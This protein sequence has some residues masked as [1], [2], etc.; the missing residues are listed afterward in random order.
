MGCLI[1][2]A[3]VTFIADAGDDLRAAAKR[4]DLAA[5]TKLLANGADVNAKSGYG[6][7]ALLAAAGQGHTE[8]VKFLL[9]HKADPNVKDTFYG[10]SP[11][12][13][14]VSLRKTEMARALL[15]AGAREA[16]A[17]VPTAAATGE[18][19]LTRL[20]I[21]RGKPSEEILTRALARVPPAKNDVAELLTKAGA[22][23]TVKPEVKPGVKLDP[24]ALDALAGT[25]RDED[26]L[27]DLTL[28][29]QNGTLSA[30]FEFGP[31][32]RLVAVEDATFRREDGN[33]GTVSFRKDS[34]KIVGL[35][36]KGA[37]TEL[38]YKRLDGRESLSA[39]A[40][41]DEP[42]PRVQSPGNWPQFRGPGAAGVADGQHPPLRWDL[43]KGVNVLWKV[44]VAGLG[45]F[46]PVVWGNRVILTTAVSTGDTKGLKPGQ[47]GNVDSVEDT[48]EHSWRVLAF[49]T[50]TGAVVW[51]VEAAKGVPTVKRH[52]KGTHANPT[53]A[54][55]GRSVV[56]CF[57][58]EGLFCYSFDGKL[59]WKRSLG[60]LDSGWFFDA[61]Y[62]W[63]F[64]S[65]PILFGNA[66]I[67][68]CDVGVGSFIAAFDLAD[69]RELWRTP[70]DEIPSW[71]TPTV[72]VDKGRAELVT[73]ATRFARGYDPATGKELWRLGGHSEITVPTPFFG[74]GLIFI[75]SGYRPIKPIF[76]IRPGGSGDISLEKGQTSNGS[77]AWST[78]KGGP[79]MPTP[80]VY[81]DH[82]YVCG[83]DGV[84]TCFEARSGKPVYK[85]RLGGK[86]GYTASPVA[87]DGRLYF[88]SEEGGTNVVRAG[89]VFSLLATNPAGEVC[90][91]TPAISDGTL[92]IRTEK[93]LAAVG[94]RR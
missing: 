20:L 73:N 13:S 93:H 37:T 41:L 64:G 39:D 58:S 94:K 12:S 90:M 79:Y 18:L 82:L 26:S 78:S 83:N 51:D 87:A 67:V 56:A 11:L 86:G 31:T 15:D 14:A 92:F 43:E 80:I 61:D 60:K 21:E 2:A 69:G 33:P 28:S 22:K 66:V 62:Q 49:D 19:E 71:G 91:A 57:G 74:A 46:C 72:V 32:V 52:L 25:Y 76:A 88:T 63:G 35:T 47:Y 65:S 50:A 42:A 48:S 5:V 27:R 17:L 34:D 68:Q 29:V 16:D 30:V 7:T 85:E 77:V 59:A 1:L 4:G 8:L 6:V 24:K 54:T 70:R 10:Q 9:T 84:V 45:H 3:V 75:A 38:R 89:P 53:V 40:T 36:W 81:R 23:P 44:P 55:D